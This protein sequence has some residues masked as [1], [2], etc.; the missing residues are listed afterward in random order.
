MATDAPKSSSCFDLRAES[1]A[2]ARQ[3]RAM[4]QADQRAARS[5]DGIGSGKDHALHPFRDGRVRR[6]AA[7]V[8]C[9]SCGISADDQE[10]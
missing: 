1:T 10:V 5:R 3:L 7:D 8:P 2:R 9:L 6:G 4:P